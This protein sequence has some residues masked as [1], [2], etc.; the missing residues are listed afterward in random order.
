M[1][2]R[3][4]VRELWRYFRYYQFDVYIPVRKEWFKVEDR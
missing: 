4:L 2:L 1:F 3:H